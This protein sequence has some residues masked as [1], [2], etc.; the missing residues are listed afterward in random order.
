MA[1]AERIREMAQSPQGAKLFEEAGKLARD[2]RTKE[3]IAATQRTLTEE[4]D[5]VPAVEGE[6]PRRRRLP[7]SR[8]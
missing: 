6:A 3:R 8:S 5:A 1:F 2:A 7:T 4:H